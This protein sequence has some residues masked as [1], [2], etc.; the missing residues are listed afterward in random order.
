[1]I[2]PLE[3]RGGILKTTLFSVDAR[4]CCR[5]IKLFCLVCQRPA[6]S[7]LVSVFLYLCF[8]QNFILKL[9]STKWPQWFE[10]GS[11]LTQ[12]FEFNL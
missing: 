3:T 9:L 8:I 2:A 11:A 4:T 5:K 6:T 12:R 1:M 7:Q 10:V